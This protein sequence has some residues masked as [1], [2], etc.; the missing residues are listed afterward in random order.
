MPE[1]ILYFLPGTMVS[2]STDA[3]KKSRTTALPV[4]IS[5]F[6]NGTPE[7]GNTIHKPK[8]QPLYSVGSHLFPLIRHFANE[9]NPFGFRI[10]HRTHQL[11][12]SF[13]P[14]PN[15][16]KQ[17][18]RTPPSNAIS[19][20]GAPLSRPPP[21]PPRRPCQIPCALSTPTCY[22]RAALLRSPPIPPNPRPT[23]WTLPITRDQTE[24]IFSGLVFPDEGQ[25]LAMLPTDSRTATVP[26]IWLGCLSRN[27]HRCIHG[28][29]DHV[30]IATALHLT[31]WL[32]LLS[33]N[34]RAPSNYLLRLPWPKLPACTRPPTV[35][36]GQPFSIPTSVLRP[37][38]TFPSFPNHK[39]NNGLLLATQL[40]TYRPFNPIHCHQRPFG[41]PRRHNN[42]GPSQQWFTGARASMLPSI[43]PFSYPPWFSTTSSYSP[44]C[45]F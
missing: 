38:T 3:G 30:E 43:L 11:P 35:P 37:T 12:A 45:F 36:P 6:G 19:F 16:T 7:T 24:P 18:C 26:S 4:R 41:F 1:I 2:K 15:A 20:H 44:V 39:T 22:H 28:I 31:V 32:V 25:R 5:R 8:K 42:R 29:A 10:S 40:F 13:R 34:I 9:Q 14:F 33:K 21:L 27:C 17:L 23:T